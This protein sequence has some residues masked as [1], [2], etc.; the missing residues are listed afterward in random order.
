MSWELHAGDGVA[1]MMALQERVDVVI[2]DPPYDEHSQTR[3]RRGC[4]GY[5][6]PTRPGALRAQTNRRRELGFASMT[7]ELMRSS[8]LGFARIVRRWCLVFCSLEMISA[9]GA[10]LEAAGLQYVRTCIWV[11]KGATPQFTGDRPA[12]GAEAIV[13][14][15]PKGRK[16]WNGGG[17]H[18][19]FTHPI[20][21]NR[22]G[23]TPR[24]HSTQKPLALM[25][26]LVE[27]FTDRGEL[28]ADPFA[29]SAT[30]GVAAVNKG[31]RFVGWEIDA[32]V[33]EVA[34]RRLEGNA[35]TGELKQCAI[36]SK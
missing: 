31:R 21:L 9:W 2:T 27:L 5:H 32:D 3:Q 14:A 7:P 24:L 35:T 26:Q 29:G 6:E 1:G 28:V 23:K 11:K 18:G 33:A 25:E 4:T 16:R 15:H 13:C 12:N 17:K 20:V 22:S 30:T 36:S 19:V 34:R 8:A 10:A